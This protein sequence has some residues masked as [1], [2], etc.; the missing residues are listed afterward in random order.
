MSKKHLHDELTALDDEIERLET[1]RTE[2]IVKMETAG[3]REI[4]ASNVIRFTKSSRITI[5]RPASDDW[6]SDPV[7]TSAG[8]RT[9]RM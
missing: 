9:E 8:R 6:L 4:L 1:R 7:P 3:L 5:S 2:V